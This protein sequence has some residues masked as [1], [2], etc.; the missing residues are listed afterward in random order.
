M[1][2]DSIFYTKIM[3]LNRKYGSWS[4]VTIGL[5]HTITSSIRK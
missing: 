2:D 5:H 1:M 4:V 3:A